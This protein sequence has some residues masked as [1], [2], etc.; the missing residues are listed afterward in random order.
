MQGPEHMGK[1]VERASLATSRDTKAMAASRAKADLRDLAV[2]LEVDLQVGEAKPA[3]TAVDGAGAKA[4]H[5]PPFSAKVAS[6]F[7][8]GGF[9]LGKTSLPL[10]G[11]IPS[12]LNVSHCT[13]PP[14]QKVRNCLRWWE[15]KAP[16][17]FKFDKVWGGAPFR[18]P[19]WC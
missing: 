3:R 4:C 2:D 6:S 15:G 5:P 1:A 12:M 7:S 18:P 8:Q 10:D 17:R 13:I 16:P 11:P 14:F 9:T 19:L